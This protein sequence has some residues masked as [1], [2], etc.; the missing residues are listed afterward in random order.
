V[1]LDNPA[2]NEFITNFIELCNP[3]KIFVAT[4]TR[5]DLKY[6]REAAVRNH[7]EKNLGMKGHTIHF[8]GYH[9]QAR[10]KTHTKFLLPK[11]H[12][13]LIVLSLVISNKG[14]FQATRLGIISML[15]IG[16]VMTRG[17]KSLMMMFNVPWSIFGWDSGLPQ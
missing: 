9:D 1:R 13:W 12:Q 17:G 8:D 11:S 3:E 4:D 16:I 15:I 5:E 7:E 14:G 2:T 10:D 6:T